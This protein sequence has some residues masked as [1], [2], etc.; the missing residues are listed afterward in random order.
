MNRPVRTKTPAGEDIV[1]MPVADYE[2]LLELAED[3]RDSRIAEKVLAEMAAGNVELLTH[4][5]VNALLAAPSPV[6]FWRKRR[7]R[8]SL[9]A[10][11]RGVESRCRGL[12]APGRAEKGQGSARE[13]AY[14]GKVVSPIRY[15]STPRAHWRPSRI[16]QTTSDWPRRMSPQAKTLSRLAL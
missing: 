15:S 10:A 14:R 11:G 4:A 9:A 7:R 1:M 12:A 3:L 2:R 13:I 8:E 16:A 5:E 6:A